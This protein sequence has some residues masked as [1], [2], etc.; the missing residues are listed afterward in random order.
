MGAG[1]LT[2]GADGDGKMGMGPALFLSILP[3][4]GPGEK[5]SGL[6]SDT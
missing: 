3:P 1:Q 4:I 5:T 2:I 6:Y